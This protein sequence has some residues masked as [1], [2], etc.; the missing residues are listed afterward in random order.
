MS[1]ISG[2]LFSAATATAALP[3]NKSFALFFY[4]LVA[5]LI[6]LHEHHHCRRHPSWSSSLSSFLLFSLS[7]SHSYFIII[8][9][10]SNPLPLYVHVLVPLALWHNSGMIPSLFSPLAL[11]FLLLL[12]FLPFCQHQIQ[13]CQWWPNPGV[14]PFIQWIFSQMKTQL[15]LH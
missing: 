7:F 2:V 11:C 8:H 1:S 4:T 15:I 9:L 13:I 6:E 12:H 14:H 5:M 3:S 10:T